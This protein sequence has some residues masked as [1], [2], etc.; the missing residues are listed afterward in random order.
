MPYQALESLGS[1]FDYI[2]YGSLRYLYRADCAFAHASL[3]Y[4]NS[5]C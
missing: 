3:N 4:M 1:S 5:P 2:M